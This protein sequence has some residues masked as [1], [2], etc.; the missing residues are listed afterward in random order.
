[1]LLFSKNFL[2]SASYSEKQK[3]KKIEDN[4]QLKKKNSNEKFLKKKNKKKTNL[5]IVLSD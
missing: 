1:M 4:Y 2:N 3:K 5:K